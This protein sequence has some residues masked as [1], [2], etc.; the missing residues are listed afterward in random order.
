LLEELVDQGGFSVVN[1]GNDGDISDCTLIHNVLASH[2]KRFIP[3]LGKKIDILNESRGKGKEKPKNQQDKEM[4]RAVAVRS[5]GICFFS[6]KKW[7]VLKIHPTLRHKKNIW[8]AAIREYSSI[9]HYV[10]FCFIYGPICGVLWRL[11]GDGE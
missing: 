9:T 6:E 10:V 8:Q 4:K 7:F 3:R 5:W 2:E 1:V 11:D